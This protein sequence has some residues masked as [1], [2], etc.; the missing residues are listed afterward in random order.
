MLVIKRLIAVGVTAGSLGCA[1]PVPTEPS[2]QVVGLHDSPISRPAGGNCRT[3]IELLPP[4]PGQA[5]NVQEIRIALD[6]N[7]RHLG[8]VSGVSLQSI[9]FT[10]PTSYLLSAT[11]VYTAA[12]GHELHTSFAGAG[13]LDQDIVTFSGTE[14]YVG[15]TGRFDGATGSA[16]LV[17]AASLTS[18]SGSYQTTGTH[19]F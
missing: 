15:G 14:S 3:T 12:N 6:C 13:I 2:L 7:L 16:T 10:G 19:T 4:A 1:A 17:G 18:L 8:R 5:P 11:T 9:I